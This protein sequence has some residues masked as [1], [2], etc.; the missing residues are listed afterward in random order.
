MR[1]SRRQAFLKDQGLEL[2]KTVERPTDSRIYKSKAG[3]KVKE[4]HT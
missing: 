4:H 2:S 3:K 1:Q